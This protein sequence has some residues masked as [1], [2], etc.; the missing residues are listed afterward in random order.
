MDMYGF[1][2]GQIFDAY[3][4]LGAHVTGEGVVFRTFAPN[5]A[6]VRLLCEGREIP[7]EAV[8]DRNFYEATLPGARPGDLYEYRIYH[9]DGGHTDHCDP[10]GFQME[11]RPGHRSVVCELGKYQFRDGAWMKA[12][13]AQLEGPLNIYELHLGSWRKKGAG[14]EDWYRYDQLSAS[15]PATRAGAIRTPAFMPPPAGTAPRR[16]SRGSLTPSIKMA[17]G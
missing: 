4:Y 15:T 9:R 10:Y 14:Q 3:E 8:Y 2:R 16:S 7:M 5:A 11:L 12:R 6:G 13:N 1:Y 17:S